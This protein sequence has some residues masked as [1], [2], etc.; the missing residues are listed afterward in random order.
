MIQRIAAA[1]LA[2]A[3]L[4]ICAAAQQSH[5]LF[6]I[7]PE[8]MDAPVDIRIGDCMTVDA[9]TN[10]LFAFGET[11]VSAMVNHKG[12]ILSLFVSPTSGTY[13]TALQAE[14]DV[15]CVTGYGDTFTNISASN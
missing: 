8:S 13:T 14:G 11:D 4:P 3:L 2:A 5:D 12:A 7:E 10:R 6:D 1:A 9:L 15:Y